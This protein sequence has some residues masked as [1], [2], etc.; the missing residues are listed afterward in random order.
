MSTHPA[1]FSRKK[2]AGFTFIDR[3]KFIESS[4]AEESYPIIIENDVWIGYR[5][6]ILSGIRIGNGAIV[7][8]GSVVTRDVPPYSIVGGVPARIIRYRFNQEIIRELLTDKWWDN[9]FEWIKEHADLF[10]NCEQY[11]KFYRKK[12]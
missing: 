7:A 10:E 1:F 3:Q 5:V 2:Q 12:N 4:Y 8:A 11:L 9:S 6:T